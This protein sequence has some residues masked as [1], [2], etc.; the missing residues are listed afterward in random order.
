MQLI[1]AVVPSTRVGPIMVALRLFGVRGLTLSRVY[2]IDMAGAKAE[3]Y[4]GVPQR[5]A[6][7]ARARLDILASNDDTRD[8][9]RVIIRAG[10]PKSRPTTPVGV[11]VT[12]V[13]EVVR[14]SSGERGLAAL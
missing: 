11:W 8:L 9:V 12:P 7:T 3:V 4:R 10:V 13:D 14:I 2:A 1:T 5:T 6:L